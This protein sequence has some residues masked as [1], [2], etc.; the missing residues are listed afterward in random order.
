MKIS[1]GQILVLLTIF[2]FLFGDIQ[3]LKK[4]LVS[5]FNDFKNNLKKNNDRK[6]GT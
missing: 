5:V 3:N 4:K 2:F 6:K 1:F